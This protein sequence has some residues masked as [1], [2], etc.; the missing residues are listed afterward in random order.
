MTTSSFY[1]TAGLLLF[2]LA[3]CSSGPSE[4]LDT[5]E[6]EATVRATVIP[7]QF[8]PGEEAF[9]AHCIACHGER[10]LGTQQGPPL[11]HI[12]YEPNHHADI[13][14]RYAVERG[15]RAHHWSFGDMAPLPGVSDEEIEAI[16]QYI[17]FLQ[18]EVGID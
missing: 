11:V 18:R 10:A 7:A 16:I 1:R 6:I 8:T 14:F 15:V 9:N 3:G 13:A 2:A 5:A 17:R 4:A 12:I